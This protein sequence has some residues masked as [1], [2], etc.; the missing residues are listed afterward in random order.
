MQRVLVTGGAGFIG[1]HLTEELVRRGYQVRVLDNFFRGKLENLD[2]CRLEIDLVVGDITDP[3]IVKGAIHGVDTIFHMASINGTSYFYEIPSKVLDCSIQGMLTLLNALPGSNVE[4]VI[5][6]SSAEVYGIPYQFPTP[7]DHP[8]TIPDPTNPRWSYSGGKI[9]GE[10]MLLHHAPILQ[11]T[12]IILRYHNSY[13]PRMGWNHVI[14]EFL[15]RM[16]TG[17]PFTILGTGNE[18]R[19]FCYFSDTVEASLLAASLTTASGEILNIGNPSE[20]S[21]NNLVTILEEITNIPVIRQY[22]PFPQ[23]GTKR[24]LPSIKKAE[25]LLGYRPRVDLRD[26]LKYTY[27]WCKKELSKRSTEFHAKN[28]G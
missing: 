28:A 6:A 8:L 25:T 18:T 13:G 15:R 21:I 17:E 26:G 10:L 4:R 16:L 3:D 14:S 2:S 23:A 24:R 12:P 19:S 1:S 5:Y 11:I 27:E 20:I 9:A 7:E 22:I